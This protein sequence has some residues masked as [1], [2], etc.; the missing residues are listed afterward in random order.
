M[1]LRV[2]WHVEQGLTEIFN[3]ASMSQQILE[4]LHYRKQR[5]H[6]LHR[7]SSYLITHVNL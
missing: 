4:N 6:Y 1:V 7:V 3:S 2:L 5:V